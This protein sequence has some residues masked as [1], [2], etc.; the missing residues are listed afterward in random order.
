LESELFGHER[1]AFTGAVSQRMGKFELADRGTIFLDEI[2]EM[3]MALQSKLL[4]V[5]QEKEIERVGGSKTIGI[6]VRLVTASNRDLEAEA[7]EG[8][9]REDLFF[10]LNVVPICVPPLRERP[11]DIPLLAEHFLQVYGQRYQ[12]QVVE[13]S[14]EALS[15]CQAY[16]WP[17]NV[18]ELENVIQRSLLL[19]EGTTIGIES[20]PLGDGVEGTRSPGGL[21]DPSI[22]TD[23]S[24]PLSKKLDSV[25]EF[26][27]EIVIRAALRE[28]A[29]KR[30][31]AAELLGI[32][33]KSLFNKMQKY[34]LFE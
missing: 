32:S 6:D 8:R 22:A 9:F 29:G 24:V 21:V 19:T 12:K 4:R 11:E 16:P 14:P 20:L 26:I 15:W 18:R 5:I 25:T 31:D 34:D 2:G 3:P 10:R 1:G 13:L 7:R 27:E 17:G 30:Q 28:T 33:R 23:F